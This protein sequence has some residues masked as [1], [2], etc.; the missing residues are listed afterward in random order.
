MRTSKISTIFSQT[1]IK[2]IVA[3]FDENDD[4]ILQQDEFYKLVRIYKMELEIEEYQ[5]DLDF[6]RNEKEFQQIN[7]TRISIQIKI[8]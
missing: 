6:D 1:K 5:K 2:S 4:K 7:F 8:S 3:K